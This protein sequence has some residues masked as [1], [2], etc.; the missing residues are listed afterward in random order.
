MG[1]LHRPGPGFLPF[2]ASL[3]LAGLALV[4]LLQ[5]LRAMRGPGSALGGGV[6]WGRWILMLTSLFLYVGLLERL[7]FLVATFLLMLVLFRLLQ[8]YRWVTVVTLAL[9]TMASAY[10]FF[11]VLLESRLPVGVLG[12]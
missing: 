10:L 7:G 12:F 1:D 6:R 2:Y 4:S 11:V 3:L 5:D 9:L 8:P